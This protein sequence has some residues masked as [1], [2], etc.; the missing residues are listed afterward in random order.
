LE[1]G[2]KNKKSKKLGADIE[3]SGALAQDSIIN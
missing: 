2:K 1:N 3:I